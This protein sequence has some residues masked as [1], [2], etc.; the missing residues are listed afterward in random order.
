ML[1]VLLVDDEE[2]FL[3]QYRDITGRS[4]VR[5]KLEKKQKDF[6]GGQ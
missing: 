2:H 5:L 6:W 3:F 4:V 1:K